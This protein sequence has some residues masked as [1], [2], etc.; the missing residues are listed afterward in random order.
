MN[1]IYDAWWKCWTNFGWFIP[2]KIFFFKISKACET[3]KTIERKIKIVKW[4]HRRERKKRKIKW[5]VNIFLQWI[6]VFS[7]TSMQFALSALHTNDLYFLKAAKCK[8]SASAYN[9]ILHFYPYFELFSCII[10]SSWLNTT[11]EAIY[12]VNPP[13]KD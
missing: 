13:L 2:K 8:C 12:I 10:T 6:A 3:R 5:N 11:V 9:P 7:E 1:F 4:F